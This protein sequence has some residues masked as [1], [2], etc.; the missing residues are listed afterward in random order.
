MLRRFESALQPSSDFRRQAIPAAAAPCAKAVAL[1]QAR[2][3]R[4]QGW[5]APA[6]EVEG[7]VERISQ[8]VGSLKLVMGSPGAGEDGVALARKLYLT[9]LRKLPAWAV[10][11]AAH[12]F[13]DGKAG[14]KTFAPTPAQL[15]DETLRIIE[16]QIAERARLLKVLDAEVIPDPDPEMAARGLQAVAEALSGKGLAGGECERRSAEP[17]EHARDALL[18]TPLQPGALSPGAIGRM[19]PDHPARRVGTASA[20]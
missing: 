6:A 9:T 1:M 17:L 12:R 11:Q 19:I 14:D 2:L 5:L 10:A 8:A 13:L 20:A 7:G 18:A 15:V 3:E 16:P 4:V